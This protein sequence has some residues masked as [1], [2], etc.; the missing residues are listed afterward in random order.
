MKVSKPQECLIFKIEV[1]KAKNKDLSTE[2]KRHGY[3][4][5]SGTNK[6]LQDRIFAKSESVQ[7]YKHA[8]LLKYDYLEDHYALLSLSY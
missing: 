8:L 5:K 7:N 3:K 4:A 6:T 2:A 1:L